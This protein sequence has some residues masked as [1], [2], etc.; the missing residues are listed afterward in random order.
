[1]KKYIFVLV[2]LL[3]V[4]FMEPKGWAQKA[5]VTDS[6]EVTFRSG[7]GTEN[8]IISLLGSGQ[9]LEVLAT[10]GDWSRVR[11]SKPH[12]EVEE[13]WILSRY[14]ITRQPWEIQ[15]RH[16]K[17]ENSRLSERLTTLEKDWGEA[18]QH[19]KELG[20][21]LNETTEALR[22]AKGE[23]ASLRKESAEYLR[24]KAVYNTTKSALKSNNERVKTLTQENEHL[25][26]SQRNRWFA[27][28]ALVLLCGLMIGVIVGRQQRKRKSRLY[29]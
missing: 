22:K 1:M 18:T 8:R 24:L 16:L 13:G 27:T 15:A 12:G 9:P 5:Y 28:G 21:Q 6:F 14:L 25:R 10:Q 3:G 19:E 29:E 7:P 26:L 11:I 17:E 23:Y 4:G 20:R 2:M